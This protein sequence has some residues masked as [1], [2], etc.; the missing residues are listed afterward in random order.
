MTD[1]RRK[2]DSADQIV[3]KRRFRLPRLRSLAFLLLIIAIVVVLVQQSPY[4]Q[5]SLATREA[6]HKI[7]DLGGTVGF[8]DE[9]D[10]SGAP[11]F[12][13]FVPIPPTPVPK[14]GFKARLASCIGKEWFYDIRCVDL[15][16][17]QVTDDD[18]QLLLLVPELRNLDLDGTAVTDMGLHHVINLKKLR[19][20]GLCETN[21]TQEG[22]HAL[23]QSMP[24]LATN[25]AFEFE[26][27]KKLI[28]SILANEGDTEL[29]HE[30][31]VSF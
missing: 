10:D 1:D 14:P 5:M 7:M 19:F 27:L 30:D 25:R 24:S 21:V 15:Q 6:V 26:R 11:R 4:V 23:Q 28:E 17:S 13:P 22:F 2:P 29:P 12:G 9:F 20:I 31:V 18:L 8:S 3:R 16:G